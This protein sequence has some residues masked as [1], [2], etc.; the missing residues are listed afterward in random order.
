MEDAHKYVDGFNDEPTTGFFGVYD[1]HG[2]VE[3]ANFVE[4]HL[5][6]NIASNMNKGLG[7]TDAVVQA[8]KET[9]D[10]IGEANIQIAGTTVVTAII[11]VEDGVKKLYTANAGDARAV[12]AR[13]GKGIRVTTDHKPTD[14]SEV[15][16]IQQAGGFVI[17][18][19]VNGVL[20]VSRSL[21]DRG[22]KEL[23]VGDPETR[24]TEL[25]EE[26]THLILACDGIWDVISDDASVEI[27]QKHE[28]MQEA[29]EAL[30]KAA[31]QRGSTDNISVM[32]LKF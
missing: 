32:A 28:S 15:K 24:V 8:Y 30:V 21:G 4:E 9:D 23:V 13:G 14:P 17:L 19:R 7:V 16:R 26:D 25:T 29:A 27:I 18:Q 12:L 11:R 6:T 31:L 1:G 2:G 5:H 3:A 10:Q 22:M 20:A